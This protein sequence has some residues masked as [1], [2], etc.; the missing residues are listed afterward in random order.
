[1]TSSKSTTPG[2]VRLELFERTCLWNPE[3]RSICS[4]LFRVADR[5]P[6]VQESAPIYVQLRLFL[7]AFAG[8]LGLSSV[9]KGGHSSPTPGPIDFPASGLRSLPDSKGEPSLLAATLDVG[10]DL[11]PDGKGGLSSLSEL[12]RESL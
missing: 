5:R 7:W 1:M 4:S 2:S 10:L 12:T 9:G 8:R 11:S 3:N 6:C